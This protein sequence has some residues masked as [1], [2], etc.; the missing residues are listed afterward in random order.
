[1]KGL[2]GERKKE[3]LRVSLNY[4]FVLLHFHTSE[5]IFPYFI[6]GE[7]KVNRNCKC[8]PHN[9]DKME[10]IDTGVKKEDGEDGVREIQGNRKKCLGNM[11]R[12]REIDISSR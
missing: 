10:E 11:T 12:K 3:D 5:S 8:S 6:L 9:P 7:K 1:M 2:E 4:V